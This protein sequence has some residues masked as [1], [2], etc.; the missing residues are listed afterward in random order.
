[1]IIQNKKN[2]NNIMMIHKLIQNIIMI[3]MVK[4]FVE[5][6]LMILILN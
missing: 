2:N 5:F 3:N 4:E 6:E 1:M